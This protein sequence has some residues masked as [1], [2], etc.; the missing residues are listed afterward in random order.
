MQKLPDSRIFGQLVLVLAGQSATSGG[1]M[2]R[3]TK[4]CAAK[5]SGSPFRQ[6][7]ATTTPVQNWPMVLLK[8]W[9]S[10]S[11]IN[12]PPSSMRRGRLYVAIGT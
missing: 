1:S 10:I 3:E 4:D 6:A 12:W 7:L 9:L 2:D 11:A 5:P 8:S